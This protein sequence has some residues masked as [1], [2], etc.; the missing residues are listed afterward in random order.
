MNKGISPR[1]I[2]Q[3]ELETIDKN[4][5]WTGIVLSLYDKKTRAGRPPEYSKEQMLRIVVLQEKLGV[6][7]D[8]DMERILKQN[9]DYRDWCK[10]GKDVPSHDTITRFKNRNEKR[11]RRLFEQNDK[12]LED[13]GYFDDDNLSGDGTD[14]PLHQDNELSSWSAKSNNDKFCGAWLMTTNSTNTGLVR[15]FVFETAREG[16]I[17]LEKKLLKNMAV[18]DWGDAED[19]SLDG[20][21]DTKDIRKTVVK[22]IGL[23]PVIP[24]NPR[25]SG[26]KQVEYLPDDNWRFEYT[27][28]LK[29]KS[30]FKEK[31]KS[32]TASER[33]TKTLKW[34]T[35]IG[36]L[37][38][39]TTTAWRT[40]KEYIK[41]SVIVFLIATQLFAL[42]QFVENQRLNLVKQTSLVA[43]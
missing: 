31:F 12:M 13:V 33:E 5:D 6:L 41:G 4:I 7:Y 9:K 34:W 28:F 37:K 15:D 10:L 11:L 23:T 24:Y 32:R 29:N 42:A 17:N 20:I 40:T 21:F 19:F 39:K 8:T 18:K 30:E 35:N 38:E 43:F 27:P 26:I 22:D 3:I 14:V 1:A 16:Q 36:R 25:N 2:K